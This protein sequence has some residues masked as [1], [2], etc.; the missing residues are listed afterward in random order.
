MLEPLGQELLQ[1]Q[2]VRGVSLV[3]EGRELADH[4]L[5]EP[6]RDGAKSG[7]E[8]REGPGCNK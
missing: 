6:K 2:M 4:G 8:V 7:L 3:R 5:W 1:E